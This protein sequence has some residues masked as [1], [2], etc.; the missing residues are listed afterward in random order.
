[1]TVDLTDE[2]LEEKASHFYI[3]AKVQNL[4]DRF[5]LLEQS[6]VLLLSCEEYRIKRRLEQEIGACEKGMIRHIQT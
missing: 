3:A 2:Q 1:M 4:E 6:I 5:L